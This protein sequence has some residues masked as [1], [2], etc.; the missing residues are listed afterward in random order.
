MS[1][2]FDWSKHH[3]S[4]CKTD[5]EIINAIINLHNNGNNFTLDPTYSKGVFWKGLESPPIRF[6][7]NP[8]IDGVE[9]AD[10]R[11]LPLEN[12]SISSIMFDPPFIIRES[13]KESKGVIHNRFSSYKSV[14]E[15]WSF[16]N[17]ALKEFHRILDRK[18]I[19]AFK[20]QDTISGGK[21]YWSHVEIIN[22][23]YEIGFKLKD[24]FILYRG[25]NVLFSPNM[26]KQKH[27]RKTHCYYLV[28]EKI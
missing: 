8:Q 11:K 7:I 9:M 5:K 26:K 23:A 20:C 19:L 13:K 18:G 27:A 1:E 6:D 4:V 28:L 10:C 3:R 22:M 2:K 12:S 14:E 25:D 24:L 17:D 16:Y 21:E 15:L